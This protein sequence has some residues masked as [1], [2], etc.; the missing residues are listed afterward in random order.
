MYF[1]ILFLTNSETDLTW[2]EPG[3]KGRPVGQC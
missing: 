2:N 3:F 1:A